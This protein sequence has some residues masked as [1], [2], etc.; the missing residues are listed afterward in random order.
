[1]IYVSGVPGNVGTE[2][3]RCLSS[4]GQKLR[5]LVHS[6]DAADR[7]RAPGIEVVVGDLADPASF[8]NTLDGIDSVFVNSSAGPVVRAQ[9]N[10]IDAAKRA[11]ASHIVNLSW[12]GVSA[13]EDRLSSAHWHAEAERHLVGSGVPYAILRANTFMQNYLYCLTYANV[14]ALI[15]TASTGRCSLVDARDVAAVAAGVLLDGDLYAEG[16]RRYRTRSADARA[17]SRNDLPGHWETHALHRHERRGA[18]S[19]L[20]VRRVFGSTG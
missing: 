16:L 9:R 6:A 2:L 5:L 18:S 1:M 4:R 10:L 8:E 12:M 19:K 11:A 13:G 3:V 20:P 14:D 7:L 15:G 17:D